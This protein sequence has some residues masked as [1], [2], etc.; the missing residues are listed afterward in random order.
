MK[1][2]L[3]GSPWRYRIVTLER[4]FWQALCLW[5]KGNAWSRRTQVFEPVGPD[6]P[7]YEEAPYEACIIQASPLSESQLKQ[8]E[9]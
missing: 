6:D 2:N 5:I 4:T 1:Q 3:N 7:G 8:F 9:H